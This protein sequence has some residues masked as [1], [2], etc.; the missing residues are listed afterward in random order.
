MDRADLITMK[1]KRFRTFFTIGCKL[2]M[3]AGANGEVRACKNKKTGQVFNVIIVRK[4]TLEQ[5]EFDKFVHDLESVK[6]IE[7]DNLV[8][9]QE[10]YEDSRF[11]YLIISKI[12]GAPI[13]TSISKIQPF[14]EKDAA[15]IT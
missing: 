7:H 4:E 12:T 6:L 2:D 10:V 5:S 8:T 9:L 3:G 1:N 11:Y 13:F 15:V 14:S